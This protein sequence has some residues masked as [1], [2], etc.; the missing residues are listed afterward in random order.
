MK[1]SKGFSAFLKSKWLAVKAFFTSLPRKWLIAILIGSATVLVTA[2]ALLIILLTPSDEV[3]CTAHIDTNED[4]LCDVCGAELK[5]ALAECVTHINRDGD[6]LCDRCGKPIKTVDPEPEPEKPGIKVITFNI[7]SEDVAEYDR[8]NRVATIVR[9]YPADVYC[10]Q[11]CSGDWSKNTLKNS[12]MVGYTL[13]ENSAKMTD[14]PDDFIYYNA[15]TLELKDSGYYQLMKK[16]SWLN[17]TGSKH[18]RYVTWAVFEHKETKNQ[19]L[20]LNTHLDNSDA[21][22][23][24]KQVEKLY[25][26]IDSTLAKYKTLPMILCGDMNADYQTG[27]DSNRTGGYYHPT[28]STFNKL[29]DGTY[30]KWAKEFSGVKFIA[31]NQPEFKWYSGYPYTLIN[32]AYK[33]DFVNGSPEEQA[34]MDKVY[35]PQS[36]RI[37]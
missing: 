17:N 13:V 22:V 10:L 27:K 11:E 2:A 12:V 8:V 36:R 18:T 37:S 30:F 28:E 33:K 1:G 35:P 20:V 5:E 32:N 26:Y 34:E 15:N 14:E 7:K 29:N 25:E 4:L 31:D 21:T 9:E 3:G 24:T 23:R 16:S 6:G 19:F